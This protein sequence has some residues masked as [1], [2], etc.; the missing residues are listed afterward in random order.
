MNLEEHYHTARSGSLGLVATIETM[1]I[2]MVGLT[3][4][5]K[6]TRYSSYT[7]IKHSY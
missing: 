1:S 3:S 5:N 2:R 4:H 6:G 7:N